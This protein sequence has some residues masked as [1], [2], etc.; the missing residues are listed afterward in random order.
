MKDLLDK[1]FGDLHVIGIA[2]KDDT[3]KKKCIKWV[4]R[5]RCGNNIIVETYNLTKGHTTRCKQ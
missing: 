1:D 3:G 2:P 5:C 4:C